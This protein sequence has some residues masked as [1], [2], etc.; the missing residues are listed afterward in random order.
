MPDSLLTDPQKEKIKKSVKAGNYKQIVSILESVKTAHAGTA[1][2]K[3]KRFVIKELVSFIKQN[4][5]NETAL[6]KNYFDAGVTLSQMKE[7]VARQI[8]IS[9]LWRG[10][11]HDKQKAKKI[12]LEAADHPNW[13]VRESAG[14]AFA[15]VLYYN[16]DFYSTL[17]KWRGHKSQNV[18]RAVVIGALGL[19]ESQDPKDLQKA[20]KLLEPLLYDSSVY[21]KK[22]L[23]P[24]VL[25]S[26]YGNSHPKETFKQ[27][28]KWVRIKDEHVRWNV[29]MTF[30]N[31]FGSK[32]PQEALKYLRILSQDTNPVVQRAVKSTV[33]H[34]K[35]RNNKLKI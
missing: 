29:A 22:N 19:R 23:G 8:G 13:E 25:G 3:D 28:D 31:S 26:Y 30:N 32:Y 11:K 10:Y 12:L 34:L 16:S 35:K 21:V 20:F 5:K 14:G 2:T 7:D 15:N 6:N 4:N 1:K 24:F 9:L 27:L 18:R 17:L 33:N